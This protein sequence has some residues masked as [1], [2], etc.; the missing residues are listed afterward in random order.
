M[1]YTVCQ[2]KKQWCVYSPKG[3]TLYTPEE[4][5]AAFMLLLEECRGDNYIFVRNLDNYFMDILRVINGI[6]YIDTTAE[7]LPLKKMPEGG[8]S[9]LVSND[10][11]C[12]NILVKGS[13]CHHEVRNFDTLIPIKKDRDLLETYPQN[14]YGLEGIAKA[15]F[16]AIIDIGGI[17]KSDK[18]P[19]TLSSLAY[20]MWENSYN[21]Y[22]YFS[23]F[24][25]A[26]K[27]EVFGGSL[28][29]YCRAAYF[30]GWCFLN[31]DKKRRYKNHKG[32]TLDVNS[33]Y[34]YVMEN[35]PM[36][37]G[38]PYTFE[39]EIPDV[40]KRLS[41][42]G[43]IYYYI[44][45]KCYFTLKKG[46]FPCVQIPNTFLYP[47]D[48]LETTDIYNGSVKPPKPTLT[49]TMTDYQLL[50]EHYDVEDLEIVDGVYFRSAKGLFH[51]FIDRFYKMK[52]R[53]KTK[54]SRKIAKMILNSLSGN[55]AKRRERI[56]LIIDTTRP[57]GEEFVDAVTV[58]VNGISHIQI[59]AAI[60]AYARQYI[61][62]WAHKYSEY[63]CYSDTD[64][65]HLDCDY[66]DIDIPI[67]DKMGDFKIECEWNEAIF[68][69]KKVY[70]ERYVYRKQIIDASFKCSGL[71]GDINEM[72]TEMLKNGHPE[73][74]EGMDNHDFVKL[75]A[76]CIL[77]VEALETSY[78]PYTEKTYNGFTYNTKFGDFKL[79]FEKKLPKTIKI[80]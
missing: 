30:G 61:I 57:E 37:Y 73:R 20:K 63:F 4:I 24:Q 11:K 53:S 47:R 60:T 22:D 7:G 56:N 52:N 15:M 45:V 42:E 36:P 27:L 67:S 16:E 29:E 62:G 55:M 10:G 77:G 64:S 28:D 18:I 50:L 25:N 59:G 19:L 12:F 38:K 33:L 48:W 79:N 21:K 26:D 40:V 51:G 80:L 43:F 68:F 41:K 70:V 76:K 5:G 49:L 39:K 13:G 46:H 9:Y 3:A 66:R 75:R 23:L 44:R 14:V 74:P 17:T 65:L 31:Y 2:N 78:I 72:I 6:G 35:C 54:G 34:S 8:Y 69:T 71:D 1:I 32:C 58:P